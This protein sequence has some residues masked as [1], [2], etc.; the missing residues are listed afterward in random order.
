[1]SDSK[2]YAQ[3]LFPFLINH[4]LP[5]FN[6]PIGFLRFRACWAIQHFS[7]LNWEQKEIEDLTADSS[8]AS[9]ASG[10]DSKKGKGKGKSKGASKKGK[11]KML[12]T[13]GQLLSMVL[14]SLLRGLRDPALPVQTAAA[15]SLQSLIEV[16]EAKEILRPMLKDIVAEYFRIMEEV[17]SES[18]LAGLKAIVVEFGDSIKEFAPM[19]VMT[20]VSAFNQYSQESKLCMLRVEHL[21]PSLPCSL[22]LTHACMN[23]NSLCI[24]RDALQLR[25][26]KQPTMPC[27]AWMPLMP[28]SRPC[29]TLPR[30][31][32]KSSPSCI[33]CSSTS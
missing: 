33:P 1:M 17:G 19:M 4:V 26:R 21:L 15:C 5:E 25:T 13:A 14:Q 24:F 8:L 11:K 7:N 29:K 12:M 16:E 32:L 22:P 18:V 23:A 9:A 3:F 30:S 20:L 2:E 31:S 6:S 10:E 28:P 27:T